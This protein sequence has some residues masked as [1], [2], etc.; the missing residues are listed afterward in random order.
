MA[1]A[2]QCCTLS[3]A[4][5]VA[6]VCLECG[7]LRASWSQWQCLER[8]RE[9]RGVGARSTMMRDHVRVACSIAMPL[10]NVLVYYAADQDQGMAMSTLAHCISWGPSVAACWLEAWC[11]L[12]ACDHAHRPHARSAKRPAPR[13]AGSQAAAGAVRCG[14]VRCGLPATSVQAS[15]LTDPPPNSMSR[16]RTRLE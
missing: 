8:H 5:P 1:R 14:A 6:A 7:K 2:A 11:G 10:L 13:M 16:V 3:L 9:G 12:C 15:P 4:R